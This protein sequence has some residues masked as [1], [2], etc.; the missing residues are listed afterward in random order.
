MTRY[1]PAKRR[2]EL[3]AHGRLLAWSYHESEVRAMLPHIDQ[4]ARLARTLPK[5]V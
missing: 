1:N 3:W 5:T 4:W 2:Y